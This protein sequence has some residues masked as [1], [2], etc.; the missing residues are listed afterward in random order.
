MGYFA[1]QLPVTDVNRKHHNAS[2]IPNNEPLCM[3]RHNFFAG[4]LKLKPPPL[5]QPVRQSGLT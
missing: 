3:A 2:L 5:M 1:S 4:T